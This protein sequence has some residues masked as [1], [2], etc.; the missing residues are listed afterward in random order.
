MGEVFGEKG[1]DKDRVIDAAIEMEI[2]AADYL[3]KRDSHET[4]SL[5]LFA[6]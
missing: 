6:K 1:P 5:S 3:M 4:P 2:G